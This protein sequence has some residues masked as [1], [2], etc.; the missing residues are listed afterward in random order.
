MA[1][2]LIIFS[3]GGSRGNPGQAA[4]G[5]TIQNSEGDYLAKVGQKIGIGTNNEAEYKA[6]VAALKQ[7]SNL[8]GCGEAVVQTYLDSKLVVEQLSGNWK[9][10]EARL[11]L[12]AMEAKKLEKNFAKVIYKHIPREK[13]SLADSLL[14][15]AL[16]S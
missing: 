16:D 1:K 6:I 12:L 2:S 9:I 8:A 7:A 3:D 14:N 15:K 13:N 5:Y 11:A 4:I 10:K